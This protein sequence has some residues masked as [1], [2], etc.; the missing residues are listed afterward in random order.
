MIAAQ[1]VQRETRTIPI[2]LSSGAG[3]RQAG[4]IASLARP[5]AN[6][7]GV[8]NQ[9]DDLT[10][11]LFETIDAIAPTAKRIGMLNSGRALIHAEVWN[12]ARNA[13]RAFGM[14][15]VDLRAASAA[16]ERQL[17][18][19][20]KHERCEALVV[21]LDP[22]LFNVRPEILA[23]VAA[24]RLPCAYF[25]QEFVEEGGLVSYSTDARDLYRRAAHFV[26][27]IL[28]GAR[29]ADLPMEQPT[30]FELVINLKTAKTLGIVVPQ[31]LLLRAERVIE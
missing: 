25:S 15:L 3:A 23:L 18:D 16:E 13:A 8:T 9:G 22:F 17:V 30:K 1:A 19:L 11:K 28:K 12:G 2:V 4:L 24:L 6:V 5:G 29:P 10:E 7:T 21:A 31:A 26:V 20:A 27:R 14:T